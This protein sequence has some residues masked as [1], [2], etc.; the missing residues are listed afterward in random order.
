[1]AQMGFD[2]SELQNREDRLDTILNGTMRSAGNGNFNIGQIATSAETLVEDL[3]REITEKFEDALAGSSVD[4]SG[5]LSVLSNIA[6]QLNLPNSGAGLA[7][8][9][10][11]AL[12]RITER[13]NTNDGRTDFWTKLIDD[14]KREEREE[15][16][17]NQI[18]NGWQDLEEQRQQRSI[19]QDNYNRTY[20]NNDLDRMEWR[21]D[22]NEVWNIGGN[23]VSRADAFSGGK[24]ARDRWNESPEAQAMS[25]EER[26]RIDAQWSQYLQAIKNGDLAKAKA[27]YDALPP[28]ARAQI[29]AQN[30][31]AANNNVPKTQT[32]VEAESS[33]SVATSTE[34]GADIIASLGLQDISNAQQPNENRLTQSSIQ[35][36]AE[37]YGF[38]DAQS[39]LAPTSTMAVTNQFNEVASPATSQAT[40]ATQLAQANV[41]ATTPQLNQDFGFG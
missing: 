33:Q 9:T 1:M 20:S 32:Q 30:A 18:Q 25:P 23:N 15:A 35:S 37:S 12:A 17:E 28:S 8:F 7:S 2:N 22:M 4:D 29:D 19:D 16:R 26:A 24:K 14:R 21:G 10:D 38:E 41:R 3:V 31:I 27:A 40:P 39:Y 13:A 36:V 11:H 34:S 6:R 5:E